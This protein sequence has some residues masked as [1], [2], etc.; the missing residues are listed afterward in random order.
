MQRGK[1]GKQMIEKRWVRTE[2]VEFGEQER[3]GTN[4]KEEEVE[5]RGVEGDREK[6]RWRNRRKGG[7]SPGRRKGDFVSSKMESIYF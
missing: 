1:T 4:N 6:G 2:K 3:K 7:G 5:R